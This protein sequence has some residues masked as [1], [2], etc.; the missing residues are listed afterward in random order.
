L[1]CSPSRTI[2]N[3]DAL[4]KELGQ[5][6]GLR[7]TIV[8]GGQLSAK[9]NIVKSQRRALEVAIAALKELFAHRP[10]LIGQPDR[11][12]RL[13]LGDA[14]RPEASDIDQAD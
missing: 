13:I 8:H 2:G 9:A 10:W 4:R 7:S 6:Y 1:R 3:R 5:I 11:G 12:I 14:D